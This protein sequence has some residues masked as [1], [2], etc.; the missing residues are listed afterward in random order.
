[1]SSRSVA[2]HSVSN[3]KTLAMCFS[4]P[5]FVSMSIAIL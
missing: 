3:A 5:F 2:V 4:L 1:M